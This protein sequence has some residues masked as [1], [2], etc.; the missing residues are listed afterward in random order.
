MGY[1][2]AGFVF[3]TMSPTD[4][5][6]K[7]YGHEIQPIDEYSLKAELFDEFI[8]RYIASEYKALSEERL[9]NLYDNES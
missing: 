8:E 5:S 7:W 3:D 4:I 2:I 6:G 1:P 9:S